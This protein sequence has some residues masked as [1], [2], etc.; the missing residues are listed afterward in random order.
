MRDSPEVV[1]GLAMGL[2][3]LVVVDTVEGVIPRVL[4]GRLG[5]G[6]IV[7]VLGVIVCHVRDRTGAKGAW[8]CIAKLSL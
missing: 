2:C 1:F 8:F 7:L 4:A 6:E 5:S 3:I